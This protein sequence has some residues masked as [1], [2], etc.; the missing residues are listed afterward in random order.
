M[1]DTYIYF[2][3]MNHEISND[4]YFL[5]RILDGIKI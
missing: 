2:A 5:R 1:I 4:Y 3:I